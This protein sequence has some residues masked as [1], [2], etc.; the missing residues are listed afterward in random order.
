[1]WMPKL[2]SGSIN[3]LQDNPRNAIHKGG[4]VLSP[5]FRL[6]RNPQKSRF[7]GRTMQ[8]QSNPL[9]LPVAEDGKS[10][11]T[12]VSYIL[13]QG[14]RGVDKPRLNTPKASIVH[15]VPF[16]PKVYSNM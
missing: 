15:G 10:P 2:V 4:V 7:K 1:M 3:P 16:S 12:A 11:A 8:Q 5:D 14:G 9:N 13:E 6:V